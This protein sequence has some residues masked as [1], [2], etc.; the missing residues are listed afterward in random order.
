MTKLRGPKTVAMNSASTATNSRA[1]IDAEPG[2]R[3]SAI[4]SCGP[5]AYEE[6]G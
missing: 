3:G 1:I 6:L 4:S 5:V 2:R